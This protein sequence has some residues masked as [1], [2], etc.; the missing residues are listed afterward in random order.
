MITMATIGTS[1]IAS[2]MVAAAGRVDGVAFTTAYSRD[3]ARAQAFAE[4]AGLDR[5]ISDMATLLADDAIDALYIASPNA[6]HFEQA[7]AALRAGKHVLVEKP[8]TPT[9]SEFAQ[10]VDTAN[11]NGVVV[12]EAMRNVYDP[13][14][15]IVAEMLDSVGPVRSASFPYCKRS[16]RYDLVLAGQ[17]VNI[18]DPAMAGGALL[19]LGVYCLEAAVALFGTPH[20]V[21]GRSVTLGNG[22]DGAGTALLSYPGFVVDVTYSKI[23]TSRLPSEIQG[24]E[25]T[26]VIDKIAAPSQVRLETRVGPTRTFDLPAGG[27]N[28]HCSLERFAT[29]VAGTSD[30]GTDNGRTAATLRMMDALRA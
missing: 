19:D 2:K 23:S 29:V 1:L 6:I 15:A 27:R 7:L 10:L 11:A 24:E 8:A 5:H 25:G 28:L 26:L 20:S 4:S 30:A 22:V 14:M 21:T 3:E 12:L 16:G 9:A 17:R 13:G 18:F